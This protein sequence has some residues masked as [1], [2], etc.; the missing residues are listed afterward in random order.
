M[1]IV[2]NRIKL[3][4]GMAA[5]LA[6]RFTSGSRLEKFEGFVKV[7]VWSTQNLP[8]HDE[9]NVNMYW[10]SMDNFETWRNSD[11]FK[12]AHKKPEPGADT[13]NSPVLG[14]QLVISEVLAV[15]E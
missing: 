13:S 3:K 11:D 10:E 1:I 15:K 9:L 8:D 2:T 5:Q 14:S 6:S 12:Q 4:K 7:E